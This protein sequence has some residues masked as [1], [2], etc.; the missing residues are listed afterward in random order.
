M[1]KYCGFAY[2]PHSLDYLKTVPKKIRK[3]VVTKIQKLAVDPYPP[4][5]KVIQGMSDGE[6][7]VY[8]VRSG[9]YRIL[10][11]VRGVIV[12]ILDIDHRKD[13]YR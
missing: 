5:A 6:E 12:V 3:Q 7:R 8:R 11:V 2:A 4:T 10:Y 13:V 9:D 1:S